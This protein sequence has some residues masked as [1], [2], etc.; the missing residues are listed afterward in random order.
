MLT[1]ED[2]AVILA[3]L[4]AAAEVD[5]TAAFR[6]KLEATTARVEALYT[7]AL[8]DAAP[9]RIFDDEATAV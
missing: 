9:L 1:L 5:V 3:A 7:E 8:A 6:E 4:K 2:V